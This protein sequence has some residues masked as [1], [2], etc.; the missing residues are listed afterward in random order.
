MTESEIKI[1]KA[2]CGV[3]F[4]P[5]SKAKKFPSARGLI[6]KFSPDRE[7]TKNQLALLRLTRH[8][9]RR[10]LV[11]SLGRCDCRNCERAK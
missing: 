11:G 6:R 7:L 10:Q 3:T 8:R 2:I 5:S 4:L 1:A 9:L